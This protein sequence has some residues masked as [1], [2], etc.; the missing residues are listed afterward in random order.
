[1]KGKSQNDGHGNFLNSIDHEPLNVF[2]PK[3]AQILNAVKRR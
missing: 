1:V 3:F 2:E